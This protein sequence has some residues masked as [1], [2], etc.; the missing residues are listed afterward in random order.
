LA[1][2]ENET[3]EVLIDPAI[4]DRARISVERMLNGWSPGKG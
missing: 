1:S 3:T 4:A 2:L